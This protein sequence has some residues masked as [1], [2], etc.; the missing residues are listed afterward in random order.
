V[1][2]LDEYQ[3]RRWTSWYRWVTLGMLAA[4]FLTVAAAL[5]HATSPDLPELIPLTRNE[6]AHLLAGMII[7][8][9][10]D[11]SH[12][13]SWSRWRRHHQ[14]RARTCHYRQQSAQDQDR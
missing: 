8:P 12:Q 5:E 14:Y 1:S 7:C 6:I 9:A 3:V 4:A 2:G 10:Q 11:A 13:M